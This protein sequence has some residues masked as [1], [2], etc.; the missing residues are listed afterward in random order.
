MRESVIIPEFPDY[1]IDRF[2][3]IYK[4][5]REIA[6]GTN[7]NGTL[8]A[9]LTRDKKHHI[10][11]VSKLMAEAFLPY[12][13]PQ[14]NSVIN[15]DGDK[16]NCNL[17]NLMRRPRWFV[18]RYNQMFKDPPLRTGVYISDTDEEFTSLRE[19]CTT[20]GL[21]EKDTY[22][23]MLNQLPVFHYG[24]LFRRPQGSYNNHLHILNSME[25]AD[26]NE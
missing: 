15:L 22:L 3:S 4:E 11:S 8:V 14:Y 13:S 16:S 18:V 2:G 10:R 23:C 20:Y 1:I 17:Q 25:Y 9:S 12:V 24:Y 21:I 19:A 26:Y 7:Q 6:T 5:D